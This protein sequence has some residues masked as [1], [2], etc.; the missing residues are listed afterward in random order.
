MFG[1]LQMVLQVNADVPALDEAPRCQCRAH[2]EAAVP[3]GDL[4]GHY[5][6]L[7]QS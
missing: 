2:I 1:P 5:C 6:R 4:V 3:C 7:G